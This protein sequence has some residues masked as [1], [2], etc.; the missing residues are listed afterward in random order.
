MAFL[1][2]KK[3]L[4]NGRVGFLGSYIVEKLKERE[5]KEENIKILKYQR[6]V[7]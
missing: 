3:I 2:N 4:L 6:H 1:N 5:V 7:I